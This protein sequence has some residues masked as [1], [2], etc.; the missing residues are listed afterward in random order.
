MTTLLRASGSAEF[1]S[2]VPSLA[3]FTPRRSIV[4]LPFHGSRTCG[5]MRLDLP[6]PGLAPE[7]YADALIGLVARVS[8]TDAVAAVVYTDEAALDTRDGLVLPFAVAV[9]ELLG[10]AE[11]A[12]LR[13]VDALCV[14]PDGWASY[15]VDDPELHPLDGVPAAPEV[16]GVGDVSGDQDS[17]SE[18]PTADLADKERVGRA[19]LRLTAALDPEA[20]D[21]TEASN[22]PQ[23]LAAVAM[24]DDMHAFFE[25]LIDAR[26]K[27]PPFACAALLWCL[28][29]PAYRDVALLQWASD[30]PTGAEALDAQLAFAG[31]GKSIPAS[32]G[33]VFLGQGPAPDA[34]RLRLALEVVRTAAAQAPRAARVAPLTAA[35]WLSWALGRST[36]AASY[37]EAARE[38]DP[39][40]GLAALL[41]TM[42]DAAVLP[43]WTFRRAAADAT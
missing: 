16:P 18:L 26:G 41:T 40:Y 22:D 24:L 5:A 37:L 30:H 32:I 34:D 33:E 1:L 20:P 36:H 3:G 12:G 39:E 15:L 2:I 6:R 10:C 28:Q 23:T 38:I 25:L 35:G 14:T 42:I 19:L 13:I 17:G 11:D 8:G 27:L 43:E 31:R 9:D 4:L 7:A 21:D 29:R